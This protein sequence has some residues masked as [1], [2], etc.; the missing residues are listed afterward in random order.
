M[1]L[2]SVLYDG[3]VRAFYRI[4]CKE[5]VSVLSCQANVA[6][7]TICRVSLRAC[8][9]VEA[10]FTEYPCVLRFCFTNWGLRV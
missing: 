1:L 6:H 3:Y 8:S 10:S 4:F 9:G 2:L 5:K 7:P